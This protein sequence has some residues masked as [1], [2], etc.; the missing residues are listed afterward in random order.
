M[1]FT[2]FGDSITAGYGISPASNS[3]MGKFTP[4]NNAVSNT[5]AGD[6]AARIETLL[7]AGYSPDKT[8]CLMIGTNDHR[9]YKSDLVKQGFFKGFLRECVLWPS[10]EGKKMPRVSGDITFSGSWSNT[11]GNAIGKVS[12]GLGAYAEAVVEGD[13]VYIGHVIQNHAAS[14]SKADVYV[15]GVVVGE[16]GCFGAM[17]TSG[18]ASYSSATQRFSGLGAGS[19]TVRVVLKTSGKNF[20]LNYIAGSDNASGV[21]PKILLSNVVRM[22]AAAYTTYGSS[23]AIVDQYNVIIGDLLSEFAADG[24]DVTLID[25]HAS[26]NPTTDFLTD[27]VHPNALGHEKIHNNFGA[28]F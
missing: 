9:T 12:T 2:S 14:D 1:T 26:L 6:M 4:A 16:V 7:P 24:L 8:L 19:H 5:Q 13:S 15:D 20:H 21:Y 3:W 25:N 27:G 28:A 17:N 18:G 10:I 11:A 23:D 22:T